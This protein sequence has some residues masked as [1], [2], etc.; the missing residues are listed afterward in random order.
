MTVKDPRDLPDC[1]QEYTGDGA[2]SC[3]RCR[4]QI[5]LMDMQKWALEHNRPGFMTFCTP[6]NCPSCGLIH[7][8]VVDP[9]GRVGVFSAHEAQTDLKGRHQPGWREG[10]VEW[11]AVDGVGAAVVQRDLQREERLKE[12]WARYRER[13]LAK[14]GLRAVILEAVEEERP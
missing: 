7:K 4:G 8:N 2:Y 6:V 13:Q 1:W 9:V 14:K 10:F 11:G 5:P 12:R 3:P